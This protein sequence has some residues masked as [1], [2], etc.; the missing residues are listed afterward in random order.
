MPRDLILPGLGLLGVMSYQG[1]EELRKRPLGTPVRPL[2][3]ARRLIS[4]PVG[5]LVPQ[6]GPSADRESLQL[7]LRKFPALFLLQ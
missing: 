5:F 6:I 3:L 4:P 2:L 7:S 1:V